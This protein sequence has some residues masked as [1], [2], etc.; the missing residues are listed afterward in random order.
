MTNINDSVKNYWDSRFSEEGAVWGYSPST[1]V[2]QALELFRRNNIKTILVPGSGY[3]RNTMLFSSSGYEVTGIEISG[4]A[5]QMA[6]KYDPLTKVYNGTVFDMSFDANLYDAIYSFNVLHLFREKERKLFIKNCAGRLVSGGLVF[7]TAFSDKE[8]SYGK[9]QEVE[10]N[11]F[12]SRADRLAHY[13]TR[14]D[15][16]EHFKD[17]EILDI[18]LAEDQENHG[19]GPHTHIVWY[20]FARK[21]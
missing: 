8:P 1:T 3:G 9:G 7:F 17:F 13:F 5:C 10:K 15:L 12:E 16:E 6:A 20:I 4:I 18:G 11:T 19:E 2:T 21:Q 14:E